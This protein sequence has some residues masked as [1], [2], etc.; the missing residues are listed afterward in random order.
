MAKNKTKAKQ[1]SMSELT[2]DGWTVADVEK[3]IPPRG[4]MKYGVRKDV[5]GFGDILACR[6]L[7]ANEFRGPTG[8][9]AIVQAFPTARWKDHV[10][11]IRKIPEARAW[12]AAGNFI[13]VDGWSLRPKD[14]VPGAKKV[15]TLK[16]GTFVGSIPEETEEERCRQKNRP[17][18]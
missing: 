7:P 12:I 11:K 5:W 10:E 17:K 14:G 16:R 6:V 15:W 1:R 18:R 9:T 13:F 3:W 8:Q 2:E 4:E